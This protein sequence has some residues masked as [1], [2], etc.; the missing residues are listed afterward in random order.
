MDGA[1]SEG[2]FACQGSEDESTGQSNADDRIPQEKG[3]LRRTQDRE[4]NVF[5]LL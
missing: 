5:S 1:K 3:L 4:D 2:G